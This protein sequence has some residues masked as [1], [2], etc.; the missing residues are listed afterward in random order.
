M[1][2]TTIPLL[3]RKD[4]EKVV[5][6]RAL[7]LGDMLC[8]VPALRA[9]RASL[10]SAAITLVGLPWAEQFAERFSVYIDEFVAFPG[11]P[12]LPEQTVCGAGTARFYQA[13]RARRLDLALQM[14]GS[15]EISNQ[16]AAAFGAR[17][18]AGFHSGAG[19]PPC[20]FY[21]YPTSGLEP[22]RLLELVQFLGATKIGGHL[23]F[24]LAEHDRHELEE[25]GL[26]AN[27]VLRN[28]ICIHPGASTI[29]KCWPLSRFAEIGDRLNQE[30][31]LPI[32][33]TGSDAEAELVS[34]VASQMNT[35]P[36]NAAASLSIGAM[37]ALIS[38][39]RLIVCNDTGVS[40]IA[41]A[42]KLPSVVIFSTADIRRWAPLDRNLHRC[43]W[44][45]QGRKAATVLAQARLLLGM[46]A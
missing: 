7:R 3:Q 45:P 24:P 21:R 41:A 8:V 26:S 31:Q 14:H 18:T 42:L 6:F 9:V 2:P 11:H 15:G 46:P 38:R 17:M 22:V 13:M 12:G 32:V 44:D 34:I 4:I 29:K 30:F 33:L 23:E 19:A 10:P 20:N 39:A 27:L 35:R 5:V 25:S 40:H 16:V 37:A 1:A 43:I 36:V 28:Y